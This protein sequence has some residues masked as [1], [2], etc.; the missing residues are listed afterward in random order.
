[1][2]LAEA[3]LAFFCV[4]LLGPRNLFGR[5]SSAGLHYS[6][7]LIF[8]PP[9]SPPSPPRSNSMIG[10]CLEGFLFKFERD[11]NCKGP[12]VLPHVPL[13]GSSSLM[14]C[15][16]MGSAGWSPI[17]LKTYAIT[18]GSSVITV[19]KSGCPRCL[20]RKL[21]SAHTITFDSFLTAAGKCGWS[22][23]FACTW[24]YRTPHVWPY[25][26]PCQGHAGS[27]H[28]FWLGRLEVRAIDTNPS[29]ICAGD[30]HYL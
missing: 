17:R 3:S 28:N 18:F 29:G 30:L 26:T 25:E 14:P 11:G 23:R 10:R 27:W 22:S 4:E 8:S 1:M 9:P 6:W 19:V 20:R 5:P 16:P 15:C 21:A 7:V 24:P 2:V 12:P 13:A